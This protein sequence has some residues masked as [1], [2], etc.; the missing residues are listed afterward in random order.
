MAK[1]L[2]LQL[3][4]QSFSEYSGLISFRIDLFDLL[5]VQGTLE[6][7]LQYHSSKASILWCSAFFI[8]PLSHPY[9]TTGKTYFLIISDEEIKL[10]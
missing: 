2:E 3:Q 4:H 5:A 1:V 7:L 8:V 9:M 6:S 10:K